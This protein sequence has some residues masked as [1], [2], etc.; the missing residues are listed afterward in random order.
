MTNRSTFL[1]IWLLAI[2]LASVAQ[3]PA[4]ESA[5]KSLKQPLRIRVTCSIQ[6]ATRFDL[7]ANL[8]L[9]VAE[10]EGG[11]VGECVRNLNGS[12]DL[13]PMLVCVTSR[14]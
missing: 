10:Q 3:P 13:G 8:I 7:P 2:T 11:Q 12:Y 4:R 14:S 6:A 1:A 9:A 5:V